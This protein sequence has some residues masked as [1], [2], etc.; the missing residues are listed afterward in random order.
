MA[1]ISQEQKAKI[2]PVVK[3][4]LKK[5]GLKGSLSIHN[6][7]TLHLTIKSGKIDFIK[8]YNETVAQRPG[9]FR[10]GSPVTRGYMD[11]NHHWFTEHY[12]GVAQEVIGQ[13]VAAMK[14]KDWYDNTDIQTDYFDTAYYLSISVG[15]WDKNYV[16]EA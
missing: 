6:H 10:N 11:V 12:S 3:E 7:S 14:G 1:Y 16:V 15:R 2:A 4:I 13:L 5:H 8:N 9:G